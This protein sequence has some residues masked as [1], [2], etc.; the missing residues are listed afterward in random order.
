MNS[1]LDGK[2]IEVDGEDFHRYE[3]GESIW[4]D[5]ASDSDG[6]VDDALVKYR[7][8][9]SFESSTSMEDSEN[10]FDSVSRNEDVLLPMVIYVKSPKPLRIWRKLTSLLVIISLITIIAYFD[11]ANNHQIKRLI[12]NFQFVRKD[13]VP[14]SSRDMFACRPRKDRKHIHATVRLV[15][16]EPPEDPFEPYFI[17][18]SPYVTCKPRLS[19]PQPEEL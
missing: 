13:I 7:E 17:A 5:V 15:E 16:K 2:V 18:Y 4:T 3:E 6:S 9:N 1:S 10:S 19:L 14:E 8:E 11:Y 12:S